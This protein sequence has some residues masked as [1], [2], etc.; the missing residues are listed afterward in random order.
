LTKRTEIILKILVA[1][2]ALFVLLVGLSN[3]EIYQVPNFL[4]GLNLLTD[5]TG[6]APNQYLVGKNLTLDMPNVLSARQGYS[7]WDSVAVDT[8]QEIQAITVYEPSAGTAR[9]VF[10]CSGFVY[11]YPTLTKPAG[12][13]WDTL[14][15]EHSGDSLKI[16]NANTTVFLLNQNND[17]WYAFAQFGDVI[18]F[19]STVRTIAYLHWQTDQTLVMNSVYTGVGDTVDYRI[20]RR[21]QGQPSFLSHNSRLF[22]ADSS[23]YPVIYDDTSYSFASLIDS[24]IV[25]DTIP[26]DTNGNVYSSGQVVA[27]EDIS[28]VNLHNPNG[29][30]MELYREIL[31]LGF[32]GGSRMRIYFSLGPNGGSRTFYAIIQSIDTLPSPQ[33]TLDRAVDIMGHSPNHH[34]DYDISMTEYACSDTGYAI[35]DDSK[36]WNDVFL[37]YADFFLTGFYAINA[38]SGFRGGTNKSINT[39]Y[40]NDE[41]TFTINDLINIGS[42]YYIFSSYPT[43][44]TGVTV[45]P[46]FKQMFFYNE[47][48]YG[49][50]HSI[51]R[52]YYALPPLWPHVNYNWIWYSDVGYPQYM[53]WDYNFQLPQTDAPNVLFSLY[54][55]CFI[56]SKSSIYKTSGIQNTKGIRDNSYLSKVVS[57][58]GIPDMDNWA[59]ATEEYGYFGNQTGIYKFN[60]VRAEKISALIDPVLKTY[61]Q[62]RM[63]LGYFPAEQKLFVSFPD[64]DI[65]FY[66]DERFDCWPSWF[67]FGMTC[68]YAP[69][70]TNIFYFGHSNYKGRIF[71]W[72][73]GSYTDCRPGNCAAPSVEYQTG[74]LD[75][76]DYT[77]NK[78]L[79]DAYFPMLNIGGAT[80]YVYT[81][82]ATAHCDSFVT[83]TT[84][85]YVYRAIFDNDCTGEYFKL[86]ILTTAGVNTII[87]GYRVTWQGLPD[88]QK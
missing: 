49:I 39:I 70:D 77:V 79:G 58:N 22:I 15:M 29:T 82:F 43:A 52:D 23:G 27:Y 65:T 34:Y 30:T 45:L 83:D 3:S 71:Y 36:N 4:G 67:D 7:F 5:S 24:G 19:G 81:D 33:I 64:S 55:Q 28:T 88:I 59:K 62:G 44:E 37:G 9:M 69:A 46:Y 85:R 26:M 57:N 73:N 38:D 68:F 41:S 16:T 78:G 87:K 42:P 6:L 21:I 11:I 51:A 60:G 61:N 50:G 74:W 35:G 40:C 86:K 32:T 53:R 14:K 31:G 47:Q 2:F 10:A 56:A 17:Y 54:D 80:I 48:L 13:N 1:S 12:V 25:S 72:P 66:Y 63:V 20:I 8:T 75:F 18:K 84:G 76:G